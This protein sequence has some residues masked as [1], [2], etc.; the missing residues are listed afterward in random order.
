M[1]RWVL[2]PSLPHRLTLSLPPT[3]TLISLP[4]S[5][6]SSQSHF[7]LPSSLPHFLTLSLPHTLTLSLPHTLTSSHPHPHFLTLTSSHPHPNFLTSSQSHVLTLSLP[8]IPSLPHTLTSTHTL[9]SSQSHILTLSLPPHFLPPSLL[10]SHLKPH[11]LFSSSLYLH[12]PPSHAHILTPAYTLTGPTTVTTVD[13]IRFRSSGK[14]TQ[15]IDLMIEDPDEDG[16]GEVCPLIVCKFVHVCSV[17]P[18]VC[19]SVLPC[20]SRQCAI[21]RETHFPFSSSSD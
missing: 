4:R 5:L 7:L 2:T 6:T 17:C 14:P 13:K 15:G 8:P 1:L 11:T 21:H 18:S 9:T 3:H 10:H 16:S 12:F 20:I 19:L